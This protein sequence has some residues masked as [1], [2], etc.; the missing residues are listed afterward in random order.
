MKKKMGGKRAWLF[1]QQLWRR[2]HHATLSN[3]YIIIGTGTVFSYGLCSSVSGLYATN[4]I[5]PETQRDMLS[6]IVGYGIRHD[7]TGYFWSLDAQGAVQR[8]RMCGVFA[9]AFK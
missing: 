1:L 5:S 2:R 4:R 3:A 6:Q 9:R 8:S 7:K